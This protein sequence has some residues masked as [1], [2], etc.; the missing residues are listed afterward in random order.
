MDQTKFI[1]IGVAM[2][3]FA[4]ILPRM[5][6]KLRGLATS[7]TGSLGLEL[8]TD[9]VHA[10][11]RLGGKVDLTLQ[12]AV[13]GSLKVSLLGKELSSN[14]GSDVRTM[15]EVFR[16]DQVLEADRAFPDA[17]NQTYKVDIAVPERDE[18]LPHD[19][20]L[21]HLE[22]DDEVPGGKVMKS[23]VKFAVK[24]GKAKRKDLKWSVEAR[25]DIPGL[26]LVETQPIEMVL[27]D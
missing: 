5:L 13:Q 11:E 12:R 17:F 26:D 27:P 6:K 14:R 1:M 15:V 25:L 20:M 2:F 8:V 10:G 24:Q 3:I 18:I 21:E 4:M 19:D 7:N 23:F 9:T 16:V 22:Q